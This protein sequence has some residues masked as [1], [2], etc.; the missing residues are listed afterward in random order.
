MNRELFFKSIWMSIGILLVSYFILHHVILMSI[1]KN[2]Q[3]SIFS[4][5]F[6]YFSSSL[7]NTPTMLLF[8]LFTLFFTANFKKFQWENFENNKI[9]KIFVLVLAGA[10]F[11]EQGFYDY[12]FY[13]DSN[14]VL[15]KLILLTFFALIFYNPIFIFLF[16]FQSLL[17]WQSNMSPLGSFHWTDIRPAYEILMLF[18]VFMIVK[19]FRDVH[20]NIFILLAITLHAANY[21]IPGIAKIEISPN[22]YEWTFLN[23]LNNLFI[24][25]Y[26]IGWLG[27]LSE[28]LIISIAQVLDKT[29]VLVTVGTMIIQ[30]G[31][32]FLLYTKRISIAFFIGFELLHLGIFFASGIFFWAWIIV[33]LGFIYLVKKLPKESLEFLYSKQ[34]FGVFIAVVLLSPLVYKPVALGW[35]DTSIS[36]VYD[37]YAITKD[38]K[39]IR[40]NRNDFS[41]YDTIF[42]QNRFHYLSDDKYIAHTWNNLNRDEMLYGNLFSTLINYVAKPIL[43]REPSQYKNDSYELYVRLEEAQ[44]VED[45]KN[46]TQQYGINYFDEEKKENL[47]E[48]VKTYF[49][50]YNKVEQKHSW[51][52]KLGAPYHIYD[53]SAKRLRGGEQIEKVEVYKANI[54]WNKEEGKIVRFGE[55]KVME[56]EIETN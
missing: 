22:G 29:E 18:V 1:V 13:L 56:V 4:E 44:S 14:I 21:F 26:V 54:W 52:H 46:I 20:T 23:E 41:P 8:L 12:N 7:M 19:R 38:N 45:V 11:W 36:T 25:S 16:L 27:F 48:F 31:A 40:L 24:S 17:I 10:I 51:Y 39:K 2:V 42:T 35:W 47:R 53:L 3:P 34:T 50:N 37:F 28:E 6:S 32:L 30:L 5:S 55:E 9:I 33:N 15:D 43:G 49:T